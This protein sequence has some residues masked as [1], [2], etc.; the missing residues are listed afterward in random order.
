MTYYDSKAYIEREREKE[1]TGVKDFFVLLINKET[2]K[3]VKLP[4]SAFKK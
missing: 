4:P 2:S 3:M 1:E